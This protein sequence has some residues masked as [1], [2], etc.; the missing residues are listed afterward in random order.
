MTQRALLFFF[1]FF[2]YVEIRQ[3]LV[4]CFRYDKSARVFARR[5]QGQALVCQRLNARLFLPFSFS[6][7]FTWRSVNRWS[8]IFAMIR[9]RA[10][11]RD[12][13]KGKLL[14]APPPFTATPLLPFTATPPPLHN[15]ITPPLIRNSCTWFC[16]ATRSSSG[17]RAY[18]IGEA[19]RGGL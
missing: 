3:S 2:L 10:F 18:I 1:S 8:I 15:V 14:S 9:P 4:F 16:F 12:D 17:R 6:F 5:H 19:R 13:T 7:S 11:L